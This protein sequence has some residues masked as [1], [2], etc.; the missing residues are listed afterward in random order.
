MKWYKFAAA[1]YQIKTIHLTDAEDLAYR[2]LLDMAYL[3]EKPIPLD[4][5]LVARRVRIDQDIVEQVLSEFFE[6]TESGYRNRRVEEEVKAYQTIIERNLKGTKAAAEKAAER[7]AQGMKRRSPRTK[8]E[9]TSNH[10]YVLDGSHE[11]NLEGSSE[12]TAN[13]EGIQNKNKNISPLPPSGGFDRFWEVWP[14]S[15]RKVGKGACIR[16]WIT[17]GM[18]EHVERIISHVSRLKGTTQWLSGFEPAPMT[19]LNQRRWLD[20]DVATTALPFG[21]KVL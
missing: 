10:G 19:Y 16:T 9:P 5:N 11:G 6:K 15:P 2:R 20:D 7:A 18:D 17:N 8:N 12:G 1:E 4:A 3:S 13:H 14:K 21:R